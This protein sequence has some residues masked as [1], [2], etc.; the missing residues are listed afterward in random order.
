MT[1]PATPPLP[2]TT[3][4]TVRS[5]RVYLPHSLGQLR[6]PSVARHAAVTKKKHTLS[7]GG[8][9]FVAFE[10]RALGGSRE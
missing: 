5:G 2:L 8:V 7:R 1:Q 10:P 3:L 4:A 9:C 6:K